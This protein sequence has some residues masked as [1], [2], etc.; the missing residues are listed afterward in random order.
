[1]MYGAPYV[2]PLCRPGIQ[3]ALPGLDTFLRDRLAQEK[4][5]PEV[6]AQLARLVQHL[7]KLESDVNKNATGAGAVSEEKQIPTTTSGKNHH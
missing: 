3:R 7:D 1:M 4:L 6:G 5:S 2:S